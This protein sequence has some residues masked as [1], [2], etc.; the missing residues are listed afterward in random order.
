MLYSDGES[1]DLDRSIPG[2]ISYCNQSWMTFVRGFHPQSHHVKFKRRNV[3]TLGLL[4]FLWSYNKCGLMCRVTRKIYASKSRCRQSASPRV[5]ISTWSHISLARR[6]PSPTSSVSCSSA[7]GG[8]RR[9]RL[10][11][12]RQNTGKET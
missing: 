11:L 12:R 10:G 1:F 2:V 5:G 8:C 7:R 3:P 4:N 9:A 6:T